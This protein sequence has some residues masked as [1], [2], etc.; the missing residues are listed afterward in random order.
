MPYHRERPEYA[1]PRTRRSEQAPPKSRSRQAPPKSRSRQAPPL[2]S[3]LGAASGI[4][5]PGVCGRPARASR[6]TWAVV[7]EAAGSFR[8]CRC[9]A[10]PCPQGVHPAGSTSGARSWG[11]GGWRRDAL[12]C[13]CTPRFVVAG[14]PRDLPG[15]STARGERPVRAMRDAPP[16]LGRHTRA[17]RHPSQAYAPGRIHRFPAC[18]SLYGL[19]NLE[20]EPVHGAGASARIIPLPCGNPFWQALIVTVRAA[21][22]A[23]CDRATARLDAPVAIVDPEA[24]DAN[25]DDVPPGSGDKPIRVAGKSV[26]C[27]ACSNA[28]W[29]GPVSRTSCPSR[30][31]S[32]DSWPATGST[33]S[34]APTRRPTARVTPN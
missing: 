10:P 22:R 5:L 17:D 2:C 29:S 30:S 12:P 13:S 27:H 3:S 25:A 9:A 8:R 16:V 33:T 32:P 19:N 7:R 23:R 6:P 21:D 24:F 28:S 31:P 26:R 1:W 34:H 18:A 20:R 4:C 14:P 15:C 11:V